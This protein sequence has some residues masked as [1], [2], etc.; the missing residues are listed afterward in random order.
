M[1][2]QLI[3]SGPAFEELSSHY[4]TEET[5]LLILISESDNAGLIRE[6]MLWSSAQFAAAVNT[7]DDSLSEQ[8]GLIEWLMPNP[9]RF[10]NFVKYGIYRI[11]GRKYICQSGAENVYF[12]KYLLT[13]VLAEN[14]TEPRLEQIRL[15]LEE[16]EQQ[17]TAL[18]AS[19]TP[20]PWFSEVFGSE[21]VFEVIDETISGD[22]A[23]LCAEHLKNMPARMTGVIMEGAKKYCLF[24]MNLCRE[25]AGDRFDPADFPPVTPETPAQEFA[26]YFSISAMQIETPED[27]SIP[28]YRLCGS[29]DW[30]PEHGL[31]I[32]IRGDRVLYLGGFEYGSPWSDYDTDDEWNFVNGIPQN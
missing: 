31:E 22:Y 23:R 5:E 7:T 17:Q 4:V 8:P 3:V 28:A 15:K 24:F 18:L 9:H 12:N 16:Q 29:A 26:P 2:L 1:N 6:D 30:E 25:A 11:R 20:A 13:A 10:G 32:L 19:I 21:I 27:D 14:L